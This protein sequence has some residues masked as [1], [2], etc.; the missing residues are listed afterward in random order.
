MRRIKVII[1]VSAIFLLVMSPGIFLSA[2]TQQ[3]AKE[4]YEAAVF[5]KDADGDMQG[6][7]K[8]FQE[9]VERFSNNREMAAKAQLQIGMCHEKL[10]Q[11]SVQLAK[12]AFQKVINNYP[13]QSDEVRI[14]K[15]KLSRLIKIAEKIAKT[16]LLPKFT[17]INIPTELSWCVK[18]SPDGK[19]LAL[20]SDKKLWKLPISGN[21]GPEFSGTPVQ[22]NTEGI[23]VDYQAG[24]SWSGDGKWIAFN[25]LPFLEKPENEKMNQS[26]Y[27]IP[28]IGGYTTPVAGGSPKQLV[29]IQAR[30]PAFSSDG[31]WIAYVEDKNFGTGGGNLWVVPAIGGDPKL[32]AKAG[33]ATSPIWS[34]DNS[35]IAFVDDDKKNQINI[36]EVPKQGKET[37]NI[38]SIDAPEGT[39][40]VKL[41]AGWTTDNK[42]G[43]VLTKKVEFAIYSLPVEGGVATEVLHD[44]WAMMPRWSPDGT[45]IYY[46]TSEIKG[47]QRAFQLSIASVPSIGGSGKFLSK[48]IKGEK[49]WQLGNQGGNRISPDGKTIISAAWEEFLTE[50]NFPSLHLY[51]IATDG[52]ETKQI[53]NKKGLYADLSPSWSPDGNKIAFIRAKLNIRSSDLMGTTN[54]TIINSE[55]GE[56]KILTTISNKWI[57]SLVWSP[58]EKMLAYLS[59]EMEAP[60]TK[61]MNFI[62]AENG[63]SMFR[64]ETSGG[65]TNIELAWA[66]DSKRIAFNDREGKVIKIMNVENGN[67]EDIKTNLGDVK[68]GHIDWSPDGK[69][70]VFVGRNGGKAEFW[71]MEDFLPKDKK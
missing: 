1:C 26:I 69:K 46:A 56:E 19:D 48:D 33:Y 47:S 70:I 27:V 65:E 60:N 5:K 64:W 53:T 35:M 29:N 55:G 37:G 66:S 24:L 17:K 30:E 54:I 44:C 22:L 9:I 3:S 4:L 13:S 18:L 43:A 6:A 67:I 45:Q 40:G 16:P 50:R 32:I 14:A 51:K 25:E 58:D 12:D 68:I 15:E 71:F 11:K 23:K 39:E 52:S 20:F 8:L 62:N 2:D 36:V 61:Y 28:S 7:I 42:I 59:K 34:P 63:A 31:K 38:I 41:L 10:G 21:L 57:N 49:I